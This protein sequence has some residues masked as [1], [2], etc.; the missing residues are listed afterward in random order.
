MTQEMAVLPF[1]VRDAPAFQERDVTQ[2]GRTM[3]TAKST[4]T[5]GSGFPGENG[6]VVSDESGKPIS[7]RLSP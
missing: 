6:S 5:R 7:G 3:K 1:P 2:D 4:E